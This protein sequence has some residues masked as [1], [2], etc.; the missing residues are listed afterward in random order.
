MSFLYPGFLFGLSLITIPI[1]IHLFNFRRYKTVLF[2]NVR[3]LKE[4]KQETSSQNKLKHLL[5]LAS[6][7]LAIIFLVL[8]F[9]QP[10]FPSDN[11]KV[12]RN[13]NAIS[14][15][16]DNSFS[17]SARVK[18]VPLIELAKTKA[19]E[20]IDAYS[21]SDKFQILTSHFEGK[22][23][24]L[25]SK[26][27]AIDFVK[28][29]QV[30]PQVR[31][32]GEVIERQRQALEKLSANNRLL[33]EISDFQN[34]T[35]NLKAI[36]PDSA[37]QIFIIPMKT[38]QVSNLSIDSIKFLEPVITTNQSIHLI[39]SIT[40]HGNEDIENDRI[41]LKLNEATK[42]ISD[43][44]IKAGDHI[45]DTLIFTTGFMGW[46]KADLQLTD[47][48]VSFDDD[49]YFTFKVDAFKKVLIINGADQNLFLNA[50]FNSEN[51]FE[52][53]NV[54]ITQVNYSAFASQNCIVLNQIEDFSSGLTESISK[55]VADGGNLIVIPSSKSNLNSINLFF[56]TLGL[57]QIDKWEIKERTV[58]NINI[59]NKLFEGVFKKVPKNLLLPKVHGQFVF[60]ELTK[61]NEENILSFSDGSAFISSSAVSKGNVYIMTA[62]LG[63]EF[64]DL[65]LSALFPP[66]M[67]RMATLNNWN[68]TTSLTIGK[69]QTVVLPFKSTNDENLVYMKGSNQEFIPGQKTIDN[70]Q[71]IEIS[72]EV[73]ESGN[74]LIYQPN[75]DS[76]WIGLNYDRRESDMHFKNEKELTDLFYPFHAQIISNLNQN[77][78]SV[79]N[80]IQLGV[81][82]WKY[83]I[84]F[85]LLFLGIEIL[86]LKFWK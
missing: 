83:C 46:N 60:K 79:I 9:A 71:V 62:P 16:I 11:L 85:V 30:S 40:N 33:F 8:A 15:Y 82:L 86:L 49:F 80:E 18:D 77:L 70:K 35:A 22:H 23:Q 21:E 63:K 42:S 50:V 12:N 20:I 25:V 34:Y 66:L 32:I 29:I 69:L 41:T 52:T 24:R 61:T 55:F 28:E 44:D 53:E 13:S 36:E 75:T 72:D 64:S 59:Q 2:S 27:D 31:T 73:E 74:Y 38:T 67:M 78:K 14:I 65:V 37:E 45:K 58:S 5:I 39:C 4:I 47:F 56:Q 57:N 51:N 6:R 1:L 81:V 84:I 7:I 19:L 10:Y 26:Q 43:F 54:S 17:M 76:A 3:F 68:Q 48:P